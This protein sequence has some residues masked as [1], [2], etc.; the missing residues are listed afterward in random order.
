MRE[1]TGVEDV[2]EKKTFISKKGGKKKHMEPILV[3]FGVMWRGCFFPGSDI[4]IEK[5]KW[6]LCSPITAFVSQPPVTKF[7]APQMRG[8][9][10]EL[11]QSKGSSHTRQ[12]V[13]LVMVHL[14]HKELRRTSPPELYW[15][16]KLKLSTKNI[17]YHLGNLKVTSHNSDSNFLKIPG[18]H[19]LLWE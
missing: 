5:W 18:T 10:R 3:L 12:T 8:H 14:N 16:E 19:R 11:P 4:N 7:R 1:L 9:P 17:C 6:M 15:L 13:S 2:R